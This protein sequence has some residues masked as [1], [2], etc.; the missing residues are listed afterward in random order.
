MPLP[1][2]K[3]LIAH[4]IKTGKCPVVDENAT[5]ETFQNVYGKKT[6][7]LLASG[8]MSAD[9]YTQLVGDTKMQNAT[10]EKVFGGHIRV[11]D[12]SEGYS[13]K[14]MTGLHVKT[15]QPIYNPLTGNN[16]ELPSERDNAKVG[17]FLKHLGQRSGLFP[18]VALTDHEKGLLDELSGDTWAGM[19]GGEYHDR[20]PGGGQTKALLDDAVSGGL[21]ITPIFFDD[22][23]VTFP[24]LTGELLPK[25]DL[26]DIP[27]GRRIEGASVGNPTVAW[28]EGDDV[29]VS[30]F[31]TASLVAALDSTVFGLAVAVEVGR[32]F[33]SD[34]PA[35]VGQIL[36]ANI[37]QRVAAELDRQIANGNGT[38]QPEGIFT[39]AGLTT[40]TTDNGVAGPPTLNDYMSLLFSVGK[41]YRNSTFAPTFV[42]NDTSFQRSRSIAVDPAAVSTDQRPVM[43]P[44]TEVNNYATL[45]WSHAVQNDI[46]NG[47]AAFAALRKYRL[48]RRVGMEVRWIDG[49]TTLARKNEVLLVVRARFAGRMMDA[50]AAAKWIDGQA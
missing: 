48:Y 47:R 32:D 5:A 18:S 23:V 1:I 43:A 30:L 27:R 19:I 50:N 26:R 33:L 7:A 46:A 12:Q 40:I 24:L 44:L 11:K 8:E 29:T 37:G 45:G 2:T 15:G 35:N 42:T 28:G 14:R 34:S 21:E 25:V 31:N 49:G 10:P 39:A 41:Q 20:L 4:L 17:A 13:E 38:T 16:A 36:T 6:A 3:K 22:Q 9:Q